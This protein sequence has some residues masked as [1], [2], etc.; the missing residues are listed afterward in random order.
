[1]WLIRVRAADVI[2]FQYW[3]YSR[4]AVGLEQLIRVF[5][6]LEV[7]FLDGDERNLF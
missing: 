5:L 2:K 4:D 1:M 7:L 3:K 6:R